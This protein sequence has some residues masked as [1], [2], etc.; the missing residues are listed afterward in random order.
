MPRVL[1]TG[2]SGTGKS[3]LIERFAALGYKAVDLDSDE[4]SEFVDVQFDGDPTSGD[5]PVEQSRDWVWREDRIHALLSEQ[6]PDLLFAAGCASNMAKFRSSF[7]Y[8][9]LL[10]APAAV[11]SERLAQRTD[12]QYGKR[13]EEL[14]RV[15]AQRDVIEPQLRKIA[16]YEIDTSAQLDAVERRVLEIVRI[17]G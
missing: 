14:A 17:V 4:W 5:S 10:T 9:V 6:E 12:D 3:T 16:D 11:M 7:D 1:L 15:L 2:L 13:P 8:I